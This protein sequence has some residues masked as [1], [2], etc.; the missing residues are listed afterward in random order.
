VLTPIDYIAIGVQDMERFIADAPPDK[1]IRL[2]TSIEHASAAT[3]LI[4]IRTNEQDSNGVSSFSSE[5]GSGV[6]LDNGKVVL[7]AGH[8]IDDLPVDARLRVRHRGG[9]VEPATVTKSL[10]SSLAASPQDWGLL[11][12]DARERLPS[13]TTASARAG[14]WAVLVGFPGRYG[15]SESDTVVDAARQHD[16]PRP[17]P[18]I[19]RIT[20]IQPL[21]LEILAGSMPPEGMSGSP[22]VDLDGQCVGV[23]SGVELAHQQDGTM[24]QK[25]FGTA[26]DLVQK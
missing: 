12:I 5:D 11:A 18:L 21:E 14:E 22:I 16:L 7:T 19:A 23:M 26:V 10:E 3:V 9:W 24:I 6:L 15:I 2:R 4:D 13:L 20:S 17:V 1:A 8:V 25:I